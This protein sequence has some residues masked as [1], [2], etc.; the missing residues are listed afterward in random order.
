MHNQLQELSEKR[1]AW[2]ES[3]RDNNF[4]NGIFNLLTELYPDNA[5]FLYELLQNAEDANASSVVFRLEEDSLHYSHNGRDFNFEDVNGITSIGEGTKANDVNKIGKFGVGFKAVFAYTATPQINSGEYNLLIKDLV[6]PVNT[7]NIDKV[8]GTHMYFP[9]NSSIKDAGEAYS[10]IKR[11]LKE[12]G[13]TTLLFLSNIKEIKYTIEGNQYF[14]RRE[15]QDSVKVKIVHSKESKPSYWLRFRKTLPESDKLFTAAAFKLETDSSSLKKVITP[16]QGKVSVFFP[17]EK[18]TSNLR[19]HLH[20]PFA[21]TVA[22]DSIKDLNE[23]RELLKQIADLLKE[24]L[25][26]FKIHGFINQNLFSILPIPEDNVPDFYKPIADAFISEF[27]EEEL[28]PLDIGTYGA[29]QNCFRSSVRVKKLIDL[30]MLRLFN[31]L[32]EQSKVFWIKNPQQLNSR[33]DKFLQSLAIQSFSDEDLVLF[34]QNTLSPYWTG[35]HITD[36]ELLER[37]KQKEP[38]WLKKLYELINDVNTKTYLELGRLKKLIRLEGGEFNNTSE[39]CF[40]STPGSDI[41]QNFNFVDRLTYYD[42]KPDSENKAYQLLVKLGVKTVEVEDRVKVQLKLLENLNRFSANLVLKRTQKLVDFYISGGNLNVFKNYQFLFNIDEEITLPSDILID[43]PYLETDLNAVK[44]YNFCLLNNCYL[45]LDNLSRFLDMLQEL[46][47][48]TILP[49]EQHGI[50][51]QH[52]NYKELY[53]D[54]NTSDYT[55]DKDYKIL[56]QGRLRARDLRYSKLVWKTMSELSVEDLKEISKAKYRRIKT[57]SLNTAKSSL[58]LDLQK[59][60]WIPD[61]E[62]EF[63]K[64]CDISRDML[65]KEFEFK[66]ANGW[67][68]E[69]GFGDNILSKE[70]GEAEMVKYLRKFFPGI[71]LNHFERLKKMGSTPDS[72]D[73]YERFLDSKKATQ[74]K[75]SNPNL[76]DGIKQH[77][78][79]IDSNRVRPNPDIVYDDEKYSEIDLERLSENIDSAEIRVEQK[80]VTSSIKPG[81]KQSRSFLSEQYRGHCQVC[82]FTFT[83]RDGITNYFEFFD[84][85]SEQIGK[86][87]TSIIQPGSSL[88]LCS[89]CHSGIKHGDFEFSILND[90]DDLELSELTFIEFQDLIDAKA[91]EAE[92]PKAFYF[93]EMDMYKMPVRLLNKSSNIFYTQEHFIKFYNLLKLSEANSTD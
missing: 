66:N 4:H 30:D 11:G 22:R 69:I 82:G 13:E 81:Q 50:S 8:Q 27:N 80:T 44:G 5:H 2:V 63:H 78:K 59:Y 56:A 3:T 16:T 1:K 25:Q 61:S 14:V 45:K 67:L 68:A 29:G 46:G 31:E 76:R 73:E 18:E 74:E 40:F 19:F 20:A 86:Q 36:K 58:F 10:E 43:S 7:D 23:N 70:K 28:V 75:R 32:E 9:F 26:Y 17:A 54:G 62:G 88:C 71:T 37:L 39:D 42:E 15:E 85:L 91:N 24:S 84:W 52:P 21:S 41:D 51:K 83:K 35:T 55:I 49:F 53:D 77:G 60:A 92:I 89:N 47:A 90:L 34:L 79:T 33:E 38:E 6:I 87:K 65:P 57:S 64:P 72:L 93:I 48:R 12:F